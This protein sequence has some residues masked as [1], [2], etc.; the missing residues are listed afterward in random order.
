MLLTDFSLSPFTAFVLGAASYCASLCV[1]VPEL[2]HL[3]PVGSHPH[4]TNAT[5]RELRV[6]TQAVKEGQSITGFWTVTCTLVICGMMF[7]HFKP[8]APVHPACVR[9][10][11]SQT[12][13]KVELHAIRGATLNQAR[14]QLS[15]EL[16]LDFSTRT[17][18]LAVSKEHQCGFWALEIIHPSNRA[19]GVV[20]AMTELSSV[21]TFEFAE[22]VPYTDL[23][24][25]ELDKRYE[26]S[27]KFQNADNLRILRADGSGWCVVSRF[28]GLPDYWISHHVMECVFEGFG[29]VYSKA[30]EPGEPGELVNMGTH[31]YR[32]PGKPPASPP[33]APVPGIAPEE[34]DGVL[35]TRADA[36]VAQLS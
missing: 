32:V 16:K 8:P 4:L 22:L 3:S 6:L 2:R 19:H 7:F 9:P 12:R 15:C 17:A 30:G 28:E 25:G 26:F 27:E 23:L 34:T 21:Q 5:L 33:T 14:H 24:G 11:P 10:T 35:L 36:D 13:K 1:L 31:L 20:C 18:T 29:D